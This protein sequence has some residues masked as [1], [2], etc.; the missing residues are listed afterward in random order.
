MF[1]TIVI[2]VLGMLVLAMFEDRFE[3][4]FISLPRILLRIMDSEI[5]TGLVVVLLMIATALAVA[6][7]EMF[8]PA[9]RSW[10]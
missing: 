4:A 7:V 10:F 1:F 8:V 9:I 6:A 5:L 3:Q 2:I